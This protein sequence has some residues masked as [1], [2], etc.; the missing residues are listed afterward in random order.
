MPHKV[1]SN[2]VFQQP[3]GPHRLTN[4]TLYRE[5]TP[6]S[7][8]FSLYRLAIWSMRSICNHFQS[9]KTPGSCGNHLALPAQSC[10]AR[11]SPQRGL[12]PLGSAS[13]KAVASSMSITA[14]SKLSNTMHLQ[15]I[16][17]VSERVDDF[18][19][20]RQR[21]CGME[22]KRNTSARP[23]KRLRRDHQH[24]LRTVET[25]C[26]T[27]RITKMSLLPSLFLRAAHAEEQLISASNHLD[28]IKF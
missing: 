6:H 3:D 25:I 15:C 9:A 19:A 14:L 18:L 11:G 10:Q 23:A 24:V 5:A 26:E 20:P 12:Y 21:L 27:Y 28:F 16:H 7:T 1:R 4:S 17:R 8:G 13:P 2:V 22:A